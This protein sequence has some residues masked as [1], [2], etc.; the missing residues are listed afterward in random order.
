M[1]ILVVGAGYVGA[2]WM[3]AR[4]A[5]G[6]SVLGM[7][8]TPRES[9]D[10]IA[11]DVAEADLWKKLDTDFEVILYCA[12]T[13]G[14]GIGDYRHIHE[15]GLRHAL[16][17]AQAS[18]GRFFYTSSTSVFSQND[19]DWVSEE[20][21]KPVSEKAKVLFAAEKEVLRHG[22][23][24][25][26][27]SGIYGPDRMYHLRRLE[28]DNPRL[29]GDGSRTMNMIHREDILGAL[30]F[31][32]ED[33]ELDGQLFNVTDDEPVSLLDFYCWL[34]PK[35]GKPVPPT[36]GEETGFS[37]GLTN[38]KIS[39]Q[40]LRSLGW[41]LKFPTFRDGYSKLINE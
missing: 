34:C 27:L 38:K 29:P 26:R 39:N 28:G 16:G 25:L 35:L 12:S 10:F 31:L 19:G 9:G 15:T 2:P 24:V 40:K 36:G 37:R 20:D 18:K 14:G 5:Q 41:E 22:G 7:T 13:R 23:T 8:R 30:D 17:F 6:D 3:E 32:V 1:K 11:G 33:P 21:A 4:K